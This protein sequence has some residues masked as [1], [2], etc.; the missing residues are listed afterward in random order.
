M[1]SCPSP[2]PPLFVRDLRVARLNVTCSLAAPGGG[3]VNVGGAP[4]EVFEAA[5]ADGTLRLRT[6]AAGAGIGVATSGDVVTVSAMGAAEVGA[7]NI[8]GAPGEFFS[9]AD[10]PGTLQLRTLEGGQGLAVAVDGDKVVAT[11]YPAIGAGAS[12]VGAAAAAFGEAASASG[13]G[14]LAAGAGSSASGAH[15]AAFGESATASGA[16]S[17]AVGCDAQARLD[18]TAVLAGALLLRRVGTLTSI[19]PF[20][21]WTGA[22]TPPFRGWAGATVQV[23]TGIIDLSVEGAHSVPVPVG[24]LFFPTAISLIGRSAPAGG[25]ATVSA[26]DAADAAAFLAPFAAD[27]SHRHFAMPAAFAPADT[28]LVVTVTAAATGPALVRFVWHGVFIE[29]EQVL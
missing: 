28:S 26:G 18:N 21:I 6:L 4:G 15:S 25:P 27:G 11:P 19:P 2:A 23:A 9:A 8:G 10:P 16:N 1:E 7:T 24:A 3:A 22:D 17:A 14:A 20:W 29:D 12:A 5:A 13:L